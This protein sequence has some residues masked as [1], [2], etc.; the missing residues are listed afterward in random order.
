MTFDIHSK[1]YWVTLS[2]FFAIFTAMKK[3]ILTYLIIV[4]GMCLH[5]NGFARS[6]R[7]SHLSNNISGYTKSLKTFTF[8]KA[9]SSL[10]N[11]PFEKNAGIFF[12]QHS[13]RILSTVVSYCITESNFFLSV[14]CRVPGEAMST[15]E[16]ERVLKDHLLH[17][18][19]S[20]Y[21]W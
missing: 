7:K 14:S 21:F 6:P 15:R 19:P 20:H 3:W 1:P 11:Y 8:K 16:V 5:L 9:L 12:H 4:C 18:F 2:R 10:N 13:I 17:L